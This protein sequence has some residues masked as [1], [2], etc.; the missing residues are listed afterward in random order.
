MVDYG[1]HHGAAPP[2]G[3]KDESGPVESS[4]HDR[5]REKDAR[6]K[7]GSS[8]Q[9]EGRYPIEVPISEGGVE[10]QFEGDCISSM[11]KGPEHQG[12]EGLIQQSISGFR[13]NGVTAETGGGLKYRGQKKKLLNLKVRESDGRKKLV[14]PLAKRTV[15]ATIWR[16]SST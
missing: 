5:R 10:N 13:E 9:A 12:Q 14:S 6:K 15:Q 16:P 7:G 4:S 11:R 8:L 2:N 1:I 3:K